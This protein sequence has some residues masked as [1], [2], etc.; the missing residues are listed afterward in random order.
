MPVLVI[1]CYVIHTDSTSTYLT[2]A[3]YSSLW[4]VLVIVDYVIDIDTDTT[5]LTEGHYSS[6]WP[7]QCWSLSVT[8]STPTAQFI[9]ASSCS[10]E[11]VD[12]VLLRS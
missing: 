5:C 1:V 12:F 2:E 8:S 10:R 9:V 4:P 7:G 11:A 3:H 6:L